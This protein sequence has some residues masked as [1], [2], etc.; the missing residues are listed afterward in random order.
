MFGSYRGRLIRPIQAE[1]AR[2]DTQAT[3]DAGAYDPDFHTVRPSHVGPDRA[4][5]RREMPPIRVRCQLEP[6][7]ENEQKQSPA[8]NLPFTWVT[9]VLHHQDLERAELLDAN[10][11]PLIR[12]NDRLIAL[13]TVRGELIQRMTPPVFAVSVQG[14]GFGLGA[15]R[16]LWS[17]NFASRAQGVP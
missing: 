10:R 8:G 3:A 6:T 14:A 7:K 13:Y 15:N 11:H 9:L 1:I 2:L 17:I 16:N 4:G 12:V 5:G